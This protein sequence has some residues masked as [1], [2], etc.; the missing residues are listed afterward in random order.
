MRWID[1]RL[2]GRGR[3]P[4]A[5]ALV[6][7]AAVVVS[8]AIDTLERNIVWSSPI[9]LW[10]ESVDLAPRHPRPRMLLAE[11]LVDAGRWDDAIEQYRVAVQLRPADPDAH[12]A[13]G[14]SLAVRGE[15]REARR[16]FHDALQLDPANGS[17]LQAV[18]V[19]NTVERRM[20]I[21]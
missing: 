5:L 1:G 3:L 10:Q 20:A 11:S 7:L 12:V 2:A 4:Q 13:L 16:Q 17:A 18:T 19:L 6:S 9:V 15:L 14:R 8:F 21:K